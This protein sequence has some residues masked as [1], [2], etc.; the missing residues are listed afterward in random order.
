M[1]LLHKQ[2]L[3]EMER[4][5]K[6]S[7]RIKKQMHDFFFLL[8]PNRTWFALVTGR[9]DQKGK[10]NMDLAFVINWGGELLDQ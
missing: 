9:Q 4:L 3:K 7:R 8:S 10:L 5:R 6:K 1:N 2:S